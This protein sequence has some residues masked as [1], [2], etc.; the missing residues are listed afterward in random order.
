MWF[1]KVRHPGRPGPLAPRPRAEARC[2]A[3]RRAPPHRA[4]RARTR[5][6]AAAAIPRTTQ[7]TSRNHQNHAR[8]APPRAHGSVHSSTRERAPPA[9]RAAS[10]AR[11]HDTDLQRRAHCAP[12]AGSRRSADEETPFVA[13]TAW[14]VARPIE[15]RT[16]PSASCPRPPPGCPRFTNVCLKS[17]VLPRGP[18]LLR[19]ER[20]S[21]DARSPAG[22][23]GVGRV[24]RAR[25]RRARASTR[26]RA[27]TPRSST[28]PHRRASRGEG[29]SQAPRR[30]SECGRSSTSASPAQPGL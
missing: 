5:A 27:P 12:P 11:A 13:P 2:G 14:A 7:P 3:V 17:S 23:A 21:G 4:R 19:R 20:M 6:R 10:S 24:A 22:R 8:A 26:R 29:R 28:R 1:R 16:A 30:R 18:T 25:P 15:F 9:P